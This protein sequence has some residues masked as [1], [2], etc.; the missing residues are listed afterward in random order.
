MN[1]ITPYLNFDGTAR[2]ALTFYASV[3]GGDLK[4]Q[5][6]KEV[7]MGGDPKVDSRIVHGMLHSGKAILMASD[8]QPG[9]PL[10]EGNNVQVCVDC[11]LDEID[12]F[13]E[14]LSQGGK[15]D[16]PPQDTFW[17]ARFGTLVDRF[18]VS[19]MFNAEKPKS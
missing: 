15:A 14:K 2:E 16:M 18:G 5:T 10:K 13:Y 7:G 8:T 12:R 6:F 19:W 17:G 4:L 11:S 1:A 3:L 9:Q